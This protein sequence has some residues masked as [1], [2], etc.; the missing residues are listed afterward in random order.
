MRIPLD[1][2]SAEPLYQQIEAFLRQGILSGSIAPDTRLP[3]TRQLA[4]DLGVNRITV[5]NAYAELKADGL[6]CS[7]VG[8]GTYVLPSSPLLPL[9]KEGPGA[10]W[11]LWQQDLQSRGWVS[12]TSGVPGILE[13]PEVSEGELPEELPGARAVRYPNQI[14][15]AGGTGDASLFPVEDFR[16]A[17]QNVLRRD[18]IAALEYG[19]R[20]GYAPL[21]NTIAH[22]LASQGLQARPENVLITSGSQQALALVSQLLLK[23]GD[24]ILVE[25]P[26]YAGA[27]DLFRA[28]GL[29][30]IG[31]PTDERG[32]QVETLEELLQRDHPRLI[33]TIPNFQNPTGACMSGQRRRQLV[34][35]A[36]RY[37]VPILED[38]FVGDLRYDGRAQPALKALDPGGR[39]IYISTFSKMLMPG[40]RAGFLVAEGPVY[41]QLV[42][43]K[44]VNDLATSNLIQRALEA[45]VNVGRYQAHLRRSC[46][47]YRKRRDAMLLALNRHLPAGVHVNPP[48]GGLFTWLRLPGNLSS[49]KLLPLAREEGVTFAPGSGFFPDDSGDKR[50]LRLNFAALPPDA[51][52]EGMKRLGR[53][54]M[55]LTP[56]AGQ[57]RR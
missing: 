19:E 5:E 33:Y 46:Q 41:D 44:R 26:T 29:K 50:C 36:D 7:R 22:V 53:A 49:E 17:I 23:P 37:N 45:Y 12:G 56:H 14:S 27:L 9:P 43:Y 52:E 54:I 42:S 47:V 3:A 15:F 25:S 40:L 31:I 8:S 55:R 28:S 24:P 2:Q 32:M 57:G 51:I 21:R 1:R 18:G 10:P 30:I 48:Q 13:V 11:P 4:R 39:V 34:A 20:S 6:V 35:L 38:D 16:K